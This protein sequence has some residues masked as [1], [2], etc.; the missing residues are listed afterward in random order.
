LV[1]RCFFRGCEAAV[2]KI[3]NPNVTEEVLDEFYNEINMLAQ[4]RHPNIILLM[5]I[6]KKSTSLA[7]ITDYIPKGSLF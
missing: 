4:L 6:C 7:I 3:F 2:K 1:Q 5:A